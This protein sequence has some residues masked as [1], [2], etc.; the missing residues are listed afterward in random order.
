MDDIE[1]YEYQ[2]SYLHAKVAVID[3]HWATVGSSNIDPFSLSL[4]HEGN[5]EIR[6]S[7]FTS[8]LG[9][10]LQ[11]AIEQQSVQVTLEQLKHAGWLSRANRW[12]AY[13][14]VRLLINFAGYGARRGME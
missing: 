4:A 5:L 14:L 13:G 11:T 1:I 12:L 10:A 6:D 2:H 8:Q 7:T 9:Q 3:R